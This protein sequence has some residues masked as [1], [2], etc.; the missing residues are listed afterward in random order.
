M[1]GADDLGGGGLRRPVENGANDGGE[2][3]D[4]GPGGLAEQADE[5][6]AEDEIVEVK[7][8]FVAGNELNLSA[9]VGGSEASGA[10]GPDCI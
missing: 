9:G 1:D 3:F 8:A 7:D 2:F 10:S 5:G 4:D 6:T